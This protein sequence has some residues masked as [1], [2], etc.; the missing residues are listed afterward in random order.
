[1]SLDVSPERGHV[2]HDIL[3]HGGRILR[4]IHI[5]HYRIIYVI[6]ESEVIVYGIL[7]DRRDIQELL[8][9]RLK[10]E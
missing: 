8:K 7:D 1:M 6:E 9:E 2:P 10:R 3:I 4:E 5:Q